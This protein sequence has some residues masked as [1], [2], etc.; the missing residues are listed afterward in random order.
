MPEHND[1]ELEVIRHSAAHVMA[2]AVLSM[3]PDAKIA[4]GP[5]I[6]DG[7]YYDFDLP[8]AVTDEEKER[9]RVNAQHYVELC[10]IYRKEPS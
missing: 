9:F 5:A 8:R 1:Q 4:I 10:E 7:F 2:E 6:E 3:F